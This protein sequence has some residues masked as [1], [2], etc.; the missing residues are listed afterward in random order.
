MFDAQNKHQ[1]YKSYASQSRTLADAVRLYQTRYQD[2]PPP[3]FDI[4]YEYARNK[5]VLVTDEFNQIYNDLLPFRATSPALLRDQ[6]WEMVSNPWNEIS[7][8]T[9][10]NGKAS[11]QENV[12]PTHRWMLEGVVHL[13][14]PFS[15]YL[16]DMDLAFNLNDESRVALTYERRQE[17]ESTALTYGFRGTKPCS[18]DR[19]S[20]WKPV[21]E[22]DFKET[23]FENWSFRK[24]FQ[25]WA[26]STCPPGSPAR[27]GMAPLSKSQLCTTCAAGHSLGQFMSNWSVAA[28]PCHQPDLAT[29]HGFYISPA[30]FK[31]THELRPVFS[32]SKAPNF[33][34]IL[35]PSAW[36]YMDK[37]AYAPSDV[38]TDERPAFPDSPFS[39]KADTIFWRGATSE[40]VSAGQGQWR[41]MTRQRM[42]HLANNLTTYQHDT[43]N[44]LLPDRRHSDKY[45]Y[46]DIPGSSLPDL[47]LHT[48]VHVVDFIAR[49]AEPDC[50]AQEVELGL[51]GPED[52]QS[53]WRYKYL[54]DLDG[55]GFSGRFL[56]FLQ[57]HSLPFKAALFREWWDS[58]LV[59]WLHFVPLDLRLHGFYSTL[60]YFTGVHGKDGN[61][62]MRQWDGHQREAELIAEAGREWVNKVLRKEDMEVYFFRL[63]LEWARLT[64]DRRDELGFVLM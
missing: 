21:P 16:P 59:P 29:L 26:A 4:W 3:G 39:S 40:A 15:Q 35:Y 52:F 8:I 57:S 31:P 7:G 47:G 12:I 63:L 18:T 41:G 36:N 19:A 55:A 48:D 23:V 37:V 6:T 28:D 46:I 38:G 13:I 25:E 51:V 10:R 2:N 5:S 45:T 9:I 61:G 42:V 44:L 58:R 22:E 54:I 33:N 1:H 49:C 17:L 14:E 64:D 60:A 32:Q 62:V 24:S 30:A 56:P 11:V 20:G 43:V 27:K 34:D 50:T 53:H